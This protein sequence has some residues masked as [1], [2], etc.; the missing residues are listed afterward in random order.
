VTTR[1]GC[2]WNRIL[3]TLYRFRIAVARAILGVMPL[4]PKIGLSLGGL[5]LV[6]FGGALW[7][8][9]SELVWFDTLAAAFIGCFV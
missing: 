5:G 6:A 1:G 4:A 3:P 8:K 9:Y 7:A 2:P